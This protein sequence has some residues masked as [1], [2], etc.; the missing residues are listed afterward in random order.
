MILNSRTQV[1][2][3]FQ[4][5][6]LIKTLGLGKDIRDE[7][8][9]VSSLTLTH[10][11]DTETTGLAATD[12]VEKIFLFELVSSHGNAPFEFLKVLDKQTQA[13][14]VFR[15]NLKGDWMYFIHNK[16][17]G[18]N[19]VLDGIYFSG[20]AS[21]NERASEN[22]EPQNL[23][24][25]YCLMLSNIIGLTLRESET[26]SDLVARDHR[27]A[28][29]HKEIA[30]LEGKKRKEVQLNKKAEINTQIRRILA[31]IEEENE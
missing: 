8:K 9:K 22:P 26:A 11:L 30:K 28:N 29:L 27:I 5:G 31:E 6:D 10:A 24:H 4:L 25:L 15:L 16:R 14:T 12:A 7:L 2:K 21:Y 19:I 3:E 23:E 18:D 17:I 20:E 1:N 13:H